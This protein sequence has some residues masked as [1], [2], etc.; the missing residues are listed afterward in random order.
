MRIGVDIGGT[1]TDIVAVHPNGELVVHKLPSTPRDYGQAILKGVKEIFDS[2]RS[3]AVEEVIHGTTV[4]TN[5]ILSGTGAC[6]G[7][8]T[9]K[10]FRDVLEIGRLR[11]P[12][13]YVFG[14]PKI[15]CTLS[16]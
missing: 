14:M 16:P 3:E 7:L 11:M 9:T 10:G 1:F 8:I 6:T 12:R 13:L 4:A 5:A 15:A 2:T